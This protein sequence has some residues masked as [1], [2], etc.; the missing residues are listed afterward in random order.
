MRNNG[1][2]S[3][4]HRIEV[5]RLKI[6]RKLRK[7]AVDPETG[8]AI[9]NQTADRLMFPPRNVLNGLESTHEMLDGMPV[10]R[11]RPCSPEA[12]ARHTVIALHGG[13]YVLQIQASQWQYYAEIARTTGVTVIVPLYN[14]APFRTAADVVPAVSSVIEHV[15]AGNSPELVSVIGDSAGGGLAL[16]AIQSMILR[17]AVPPGRVVLI[18]PW[19]DVTMSDP[20]SLLIDDP[21]LDVKSLIASG[22]LWAGDLDPAD[23][24]VSPLNGSLAGL[25]TT[26]VYCGS[27]DAVYPDTLRL[28]AQAATSNADVSFFLEKNL[29]HVWP[30][31]FPLPEAKR[32]FST[33][34][35]Q[36]VGQTKPVGTTL[37]SGSRDSKR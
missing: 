16:A 28:Q 6:N 7:P 23:P 25:P 5:A 36:L 20:R 3:F 2:T 1:S 13:A 15:V 27:R 37:R 32:V 31:I 4:R 33:I 29:I 35:C 24:S 10:W 21:M 9:P 34:C 12:R 14:L 8:A 19:L 17:N 26:Y 18:S 30:M 11:L 22:Q